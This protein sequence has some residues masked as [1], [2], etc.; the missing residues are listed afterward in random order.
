MQALHHDAALFSGQLRPRCVLQATKAELEEDSEH[1]L[2]SRSNGTHPD[3][4]SLLH[5]EVARAQQGIKIYR[6]RK[7]QG[8]D[9]LWSW[10]DLFIHVGDEPRRDPV[11]GKY[12]WLTWS[13]V[14]CPL[15]E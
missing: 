3:F 2:R 11:T 4:N 14:L 6:S 10:E 8:D 13:G 9:H 1:L 15:S 5:T 7:A 12:V